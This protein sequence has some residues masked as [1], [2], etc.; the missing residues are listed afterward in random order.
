MTTISP[1]KINLGLEIP[2]KREDGYHEIRSI[3]L[4]TDFGDDFQVETF[5]L[6]NHQMPEFQL[7]SEN[8]LPKAKQ[9]LFDAVSE[10]GNITKNIL[11]KSYFTVFPHLKK[12]EGVRVHLTKRI[13]PEGGVGGG[14]SNAGSLLKFLFSRTS[15]NQ[16]EQ[17]ALAKSIGADVPFFLQENHCIVTG[18]GENL[19]PIQVAKG[20]GILAIPSYSLSTKSMYDGLQRSLQKT[21]DSKVWKTLTEDVVRSLRVGDWTSLNGKLENDFEKIAFQVHPDLKELKSGILQEGAVY[22]S[23]SG[24]GSCFFGLVA[25]EQD[26]LPLLNSLKSRFPEMDFR[27]FSF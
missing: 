25:K 1:A 18:I 19:E 20:F 2:F 10:R 17:I 8:K 16:D 6:S 4:R 7:V 24:S 13:P 15:L 21:H 22:S 5:S 23:L 14:S 11:Y 3:F 9:A 27:S 26:Q 12:P